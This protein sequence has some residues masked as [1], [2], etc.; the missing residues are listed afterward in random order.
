MWLSPVPTGCVMG[1]QSPPL[2]LL[3]QLVWLLW[4]TVCLGKCC[5]VL[6]L[7]KGWGEGVGSEPTFTTAR[8][9]SASPHLRHPHADC[10]RPLPLSATVLPP[11]TS[12]LAATFRPLCEREQQTRVLEMAPSDAFGLQTRQGQSSGWRWS[13]GI[14]FCPVRTL[15]SVCGTTRLPR[16]CRSWTGAC[17]SAAGDS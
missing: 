10:S 5:P 13:L 14:A 1:C 7:G 6:A 2:V 9:C 11:T 8:P 12:V 3:E 17:N 15:G 4:F 16:A